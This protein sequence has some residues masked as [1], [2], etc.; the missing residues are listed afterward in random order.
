MASIVGGA[1]ASV[2]VR[3]GV[4]GRNAEPGNTAMPTRNTVARRKLRVLEVHM[5]KPV[6]DED[7]SS[8]AW[9]IRERAV[10]VNPGSSNVGSSSTSASHMK[11]RISGVERV[12]VSL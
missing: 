8:A 5:A 2:P 12:I 4:P 7:E 1:A 9:R 6:V 3:S 10:Q 11:R